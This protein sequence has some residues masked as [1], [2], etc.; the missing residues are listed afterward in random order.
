MMR[1]C[2]RGL[3]ALTV[4]MLL[5]GLAFDAPSGLLGGEAFLARIYD[6]IRG[7]A[8]S[9]G[10]NWLNTLLMVVFDEHGGTYDH[11]PPPAASPPD[12]ARP[13]GQMGFGFDRLGVRLPAIA[14]SPWISERTVVND[15]YHHTSVIRTMRERWDLGPPLTGRDA[16]A[17]DLAPLL[18]RDTP[19]APDDWPDVLPQPVPDF[20]GSLIPLDAPLSPMAKALVAG[21]AEL[22]R[23]LDRTVPETPDLDGLTGAEGLA[24][25]LENVGHLFPGLRRS[26]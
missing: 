6:A 2:L 3:L 12:P 24:L 15:V 25:V 13:A 14:V 23:S 26:G 5:P 1:T 4:A 16:T 8:S 10:S 9:G 11:V 18:T 20:D 21:S 7:S 22:A 19:R 17:P